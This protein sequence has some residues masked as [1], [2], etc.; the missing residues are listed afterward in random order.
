[1]RSIS[2]RRCCLAPALLLASLGFEAAAAPADK[3]PGLRDTP[4][5]RLF[6]EGLDEESKACGIDE[7]DV[8]AA[9]RTPL[10][11]S[12]LKLSDSMK[13]AIV[14]AQVS[15]LKMGPEVCVVHLAIEFQRLAYTQPG[16]ES[17][18]D[19][20]T[21]YADRALLSGPPEDMSRRVVDSLASL[22]RRLLAAWMDEN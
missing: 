8:D 11:A 10:G 2:W 16:P 12:R 1:M 19:F 13:D 6:V 17:P 22:T 14:V 18:F 7:K 5:V 20:G 15:A 4:S 21:F 3:H 9:M